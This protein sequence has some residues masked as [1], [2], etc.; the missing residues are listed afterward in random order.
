MP[1]GKREDRIDKLIGIAL[2]VI[3]VTQLA[4]GI[5]LTQTLDQLIQINDINHPIIDTTL[6]TFSAWVAAH[7]QKPAEEGKA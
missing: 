1:K 5:V 4:R 3:A 6:L 7:Q 2:V